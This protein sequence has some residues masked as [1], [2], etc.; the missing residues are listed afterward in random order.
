MGR[1][2]VIRLRAAYVAATLAS[3]LWASG[4][5]ADCR[6]TVAVQF[7]PGASAANI[8]GGIARGEIACLTLGA[9]AG[10][11]VSIVQRSRGEDNIAM[12]FYRP[13][14]KIDRGAE[15]IDIHGS[16]LPGAEEA[17]DAPGWTGQLPT[18]G[19][20]LLVLGTTRG[21][22]AYRIRIEIR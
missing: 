4:A 18:T 19:N 10:Q 22:G 9:R 5:Q 14:W 2:G 21:S 6:Q 15:G 12:Q 16:A 8:E 20:Y 3:A 11:H 7:A 13:G 1:F 17:A